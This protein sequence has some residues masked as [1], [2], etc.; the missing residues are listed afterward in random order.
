MPQVC[1]SAGVAVIAGVADV[2][3]EVVA[4]VADAAAD[5]VRTPFFF[6]GVAKGAGALTDIAVPT[7]TSSRPRR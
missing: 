4:D 6:A 5:L 2:V 3:A 7:M 1:V